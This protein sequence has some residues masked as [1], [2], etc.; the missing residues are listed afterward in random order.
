MSG[1]VGMVIIIFIVAII[2]YFVNARKSEES[3]R[4]KNSSRVLIGV[5][6]YFDGLV[7]P[8]DSEIIIG[9]DSD[10]CNI[11]FPNDTKGVSST[12]CRV[13]FE[14]EGVG[15]TDLGSKFGT[16]ISEGNRLNAKT[17]YYLGTGDSFFVGD[18]KN[19]FLIK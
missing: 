3:E 1:I 11:V 6:G 17:T 12:H 7:F 14:K 5:G 8:I 16:Y 13:T 19:T 10:N 4:Y 15:V 2:C 9:R 18:A